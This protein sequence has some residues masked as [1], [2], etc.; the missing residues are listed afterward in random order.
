[1]MKE[2]FTQEIV[3][4]QKFRECA[5]CPIFDECTRV[6]YLKNA[7]GVAFFG[8]IIGILLALFGIALA[9]VY[10]RD[11]PNGAPWLLFISLVYLLAVVRAEKEFKTGNEEGQALAAQEA[12]AKPEGGAGPEPAGAHH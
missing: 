6:V 11:L 12:E 9:L 3:D 1:M 10:W 4:S 2:C 5:R 8:Q 7:R